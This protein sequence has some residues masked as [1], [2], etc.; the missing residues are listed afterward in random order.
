MKYLSV[1]IRMKTTEQCFPVVL[2]TR[3]PL[4]FQ[5]FESVDAILKCNLSN[6][7]AT[8]L[9]CPVVL[10]NYNGSQVVLTFDSVMKSLTVTIIQV[11]S[12]EQ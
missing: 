7:E 1:I 3:G 5:T 6:Q 10:F 12:M 9:S 8:E 4:I 2:Y 11:K